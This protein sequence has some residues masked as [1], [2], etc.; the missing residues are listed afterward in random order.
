MAI[1]AA[2]G[3]S[4]GPALTIPVLLMPKVI[5][6]CSVTDLQQP[7]RIADTVLDDVECYRIQG[8]QKASDI[9]LWISKKTY[10]IHRIDESD[11]FTDFR[12]ETTTTYKPRVDVVLD[13]SKLT[14][15]APEK[16]NN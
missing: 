7:N 15:N 16:G 5:E 1:A 6:A 14:F 3:V 10:L 8:K 4:G 12:T 11:Q 2:T 9:T 13:E